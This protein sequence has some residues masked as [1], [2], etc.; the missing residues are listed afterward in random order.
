VPA[1]HR[2]IARMGEVIREEYRTTDPDLS[3][4]I[5][6]QAA[7]GDHRV[8][9]EPDTLAVIDLLLALPTGPVEM[10]PD[11]PRLVQTSTNLSMVAIHDA[12]VRVTTHQRS[13][14]PSRLDG[15]CERVRAAGR[16]AGARVESDTGYPSW[17]MDPDSALLKRCT[18][19]YRDL[20]GAEPVIKVIHAGL[21]CGVIGDRCPGM[22]MISIGPTIEN[23]H[24]PSERLYLPSVERVWRL[25]TALLASVAAAPC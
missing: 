20:F 14:V 1:L 4:R 3:V 24:S 23:L 7:D 21:E 22:D 16:L 19:L 18:A 25:L 12:S 13:S 8:V 11:L 9:T 5:E 15:I 2:A 6:T 17:P 10:A